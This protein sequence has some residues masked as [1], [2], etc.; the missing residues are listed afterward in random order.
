MKY[1]STTPLD[2]LP[3]QAWRQYRAFQ[4][5]ASVHLAN[6]Q[7]VFNEPADV[8]NDV[9]AQREEPLSAVDT[10]TTP[11]RVE[12]TNAPTASPGHT[13]RAEDRPSPKSGLGSDKTRERSTPVVPSIERT[14]T[15]IGDAGDRQDAEEADGSTPS[16]VTAAPEATVERQHDP[17]EPTPATTP[18]RGG[19]TLVASPIENQE[20]S[21]DYVTFE[22]NDPQN[23]QNW[24]RWYKAFVLAQLTFLTLSLTFA[25]AASA[26][27]EAGFME[28]FG[29]GPITA[30]AG[31]GLFLIGCGLGAL[32]TAPLSEREYLPPHVGFL[33]TD[34]L[35]VW[36]S[37]RLLH[38][39]LL[40]DAFRTRLRSRS[41]RPCPPRPPFLCRSGIL[42]AVEQ[43]RRNTVR[44]WKPHLTYHPIPN[45]C[46]CGIPRSN[47]GTRNGRVRSHQPGVRMEMD[48]LDLHDLERSSIPTRGVLYARDSG[49]G[50]T[51]DEG[52]APEKGHGEQGVEIKDGG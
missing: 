24:S 5:P 35:S 37:P 7:G 52:A 29:A 47:S 2:R 36:P 4:P 40:C 28:E 16:P 20:K 50:Y 22:P 13:S 45:L 11:H 26:P 46:L 43:R 25:S 51:Q 39:S 48:V 41:Y 15:A 31:T 8:G 49:P 23:P 3:M 32:P 19:S 14:F 34:D 10:S 30:T 44:H 33:H 12:D 1:A 38:Y 42:C 17:S 21:P 18:S 6:V 9:E 27:A